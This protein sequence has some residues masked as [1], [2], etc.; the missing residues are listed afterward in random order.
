MG[1]VKNE[2]TACARNNLG[3]K[4]YRLRCKG[5]ANG[6]DAHRGDEREHQQCGTNSKEHTTPILTG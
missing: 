1:S 4:L 5:S 6:H 2:I 3:R